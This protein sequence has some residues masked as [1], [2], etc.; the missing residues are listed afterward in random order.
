MDSLLGIGLGMSPSSG[1][2]VMGGPGKQPAKNEG[3]ML[4]ARLAELRKERDVA[5][6]VKK[7]LAAVGA[8]ATVPNTA[9]STPATMSPSIPNPASRQPGRRAKNSRKKKG[10]KK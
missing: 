3:A 2:S 8:A 1:K 4:A 5:S 7:E 10:T 9:V 6:K